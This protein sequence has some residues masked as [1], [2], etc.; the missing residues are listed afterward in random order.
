VR[1]MKSTCDWE[2]LE[3]LVLGEL[4]PNEEYE[5]RAHAA[6]C[7]ACARELR[8]ME[9]DRRAI[10]ALSRAEHRAAPAAPLERV[11]ARVEQRRAVRMRRATWAAAACAAALLLVRVHAVSASASAAPDEDGAPAPVTTSDTADGT[12]PRGATWSLLGG[13]DRAIVAADEAWN[14][15]LTMTPSASPPLPM[16]VS[17]DGRVTGAAFSPLPRE[18]CE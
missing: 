7:E 1:T 15:C 10:E 6:A 8:L 2:P 3:A 16:S 11:V 13:D 18:A 4:G 5:V 9:R 14:A 17:D 12:S